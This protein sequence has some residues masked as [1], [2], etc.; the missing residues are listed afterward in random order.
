M[1]SKHCPKLASFIE[2]S[3]NFSLGSPSHYES[4]KHP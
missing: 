2:F 4:F 1:H 3:Q